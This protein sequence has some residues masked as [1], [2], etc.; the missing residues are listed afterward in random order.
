MVHVRVGADIVCAPCLGTITA[1]KGEFDATADE[2]TVPWVLRAYIFH[3]VDGT[4]VV[5][6]GVVR[7]LEVVFDLDN[8]SWGDLVVGLVAHLESHAPS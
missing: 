6:E 2:R 3:A 1:W 7:W 5:P 4:E 8:P